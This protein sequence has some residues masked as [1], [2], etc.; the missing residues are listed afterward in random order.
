MPATGDGDRRP[1]PR[2]RDGPE[3]G[4]AYVGARV[5]RVRCRAERSRLAGRAAPARRPA[6]GGS[7]RRCS[8]VPAC[9]PFPRACG[10]VHRRTGRTG[11]G[12]RADPRAPGG[13]TTAR[14]PTRR[15]LCPGFS[16][17]KDTL[18]MRLRY[19]L[20]CLA[21]VPVAGCGAQGTTVSSDSSETPDAG[22]GDSSL[23][24][25]EGTA[26][27]PDGE[28]AAGCAVSPESVGDRKSVV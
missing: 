26:T 10:G 15:S 21:L 23:G 25:A 9:P 19:L 27:T 13:R 12:Q 22:G 4:G 3:A 18:N 14:R 17:W 5:R 28:P 6:R 11:S 16:G 24:T 20:L 1:H 2:V 7:G 8:P